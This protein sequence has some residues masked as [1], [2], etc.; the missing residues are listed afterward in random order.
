MNLA[1]RSAASSACSWSVQKSLT[2]DG[3]FQMARTAAPI[4]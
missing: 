4:R 2:L 3:R 1:S